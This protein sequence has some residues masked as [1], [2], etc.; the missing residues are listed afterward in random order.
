MISEIKPYWAKCKIC[1]NRSKRKNI[2]CS[3]LC[4][5]F[6]DT[7]GLGEARYY[8][9]IWKEGLRYVECDEEDYIRPITITVSNG[10]IF[11]EYGMWVKDV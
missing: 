6:V 9:K 4:Q 5:L 8:Y 2:F 3:E 7:Y 10:A 11:E 1:L